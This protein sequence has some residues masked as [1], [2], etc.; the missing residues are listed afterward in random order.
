MDFIYYLFST[1]LF[2]AVCCK[3]QINIKS[4]YLYRLLKNIRKSVMISNMNIKKGEKY[5]KIKK[6][7]KKLFIW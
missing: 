2:Y 3:L 7:H 1:T 5:V 6:Y 4:K